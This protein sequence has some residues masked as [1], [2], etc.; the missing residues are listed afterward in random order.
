MSLSG[1]AVPF[2]VLLL[3]IPLG[4]LAEPEEIADGV[5]IVRGGFPLKT[6]NV[7]LVRDGGT[8]P[9]LNSQRAHLTATAM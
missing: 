8:V 7:Y 4:R 9:P 6:M 3:G 1:R 5:W 2:F